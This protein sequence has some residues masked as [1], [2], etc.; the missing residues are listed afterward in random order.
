[1]T[2]T[3]PQVIDR[4][5][6]RRL[7]AE[8]PPR[9][10]CAAL[11][12]LAAAFEQGRGDRAGCVGGVRTVERGLPVYEIGEESRSLFFIRRGLVKIGTV[13][14]D[15]HEFIYGLR[16]DGE[17]FGELCALPGPRRDR[18]LALER[19]TLVSMPLETL[20]CAIQADGEALRQFVGLCSA[21]L[22]DAYEQL[23]LVAFGDTVE[24][25]VSLLVR[26]GGRLGRPAGRS[27]EISAYVTQEEIAQMIGVRRERL[28]TAMNFLRK[29]RYV[30]YARGGR[31]VLDLAALQGYR[32]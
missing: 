25:L 3:E 23:H 28:S 5:A 26:L 22:S 24:R 20:L 21:S 29:R 7:A 19:T 32:R 4:G 8:G 9:A 1:M 17:I 14:P 16:Q 27:V 10:A 2:R 12:G 11:T 15:G 30:D 31:I 13:T 18:A 6:T